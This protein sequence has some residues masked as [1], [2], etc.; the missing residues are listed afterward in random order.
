RKLFHL[1]EIPV[2]FGYSFA[3]YFWS[4]KIAIMVLTA[5]FLLLMEIEYVRLEVKIKLPSFLDVLRPRERNNVTGAIFF[6][7]ATIIVF[8][9]F[10]YGVALLAL[11]LTVFGDLASALIGIKFGK[12]E[13]FRH[14]TMEGFIAGLITNLLVGWMIIPMYPAVFIT[15]AIVASV[16][17]LLTG[18]LDDNLTVPLFAGFT[19]QVIAYSI[20]ATLTGFPGPLEPIFR[21]LYGLLFFN[22]PLGLSLKILGSRLRRL[23]PLGNGTKT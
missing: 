11:F 20:G 13:I 19:G 9:A 4:E 1:L 15:M 7:A 8:A 6:V 21:L 16:V 12:H 22:K 3:R 23:L 18:K 2:L 5:L 14:K 10:D 17:E